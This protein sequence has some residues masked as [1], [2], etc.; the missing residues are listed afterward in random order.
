[1]KYNAKRKNIDIEQ[2]WHK[3]DGFIADMGE[4]PPDYRLN[5]KDNNLGFIRGNC[6]WIQ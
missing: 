6:R 3:F 1:M 4:C 2:N 5:R